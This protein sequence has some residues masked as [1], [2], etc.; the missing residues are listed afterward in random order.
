[1]EPP[2]Y[3]NKPI[4]AIMNSDGRIPGKGTVTVTVAA[5]RFCEPVQRSADRSAANPTRSRSGGHTASGRVPGMRFRATGRH[6]LCHPTRHITRRFGKEGRNWF[7]PA[8]VKLR[9]PCAERPAIRRSGRPRPGLPCTRSYSCRPLVERRFQIPEWL[10][11]T[12]ARPNTNVPDPS[13]LCQGLDCVAG[14]YRDSG[15]PSLP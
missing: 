13:A 15:L 1:M 3:G 4:S 2:V 5:N 7:W 12:C 14:I 8:R 6:G 10:A 9:F 11:D